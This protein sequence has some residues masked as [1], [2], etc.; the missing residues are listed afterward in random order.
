MTREVLTSSQN[1]EECKTLTCGKKFRAE[2]E[3]V[4]AWLDNHFK[5]SGVVCRCRFTPG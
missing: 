1:V 2:A 4:H 5:R 3:E